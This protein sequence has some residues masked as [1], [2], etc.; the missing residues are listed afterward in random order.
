MSTST[1]RPA[2]TARWLAPELLIGSG[3]TSKASDVYAYACVC[4]EIF[5]GGCHPFPELPNE[6][7]VALSVTQGKR[8]VRPRNVPKLR[9]E[10]WAL[11]ELCWDGVPASRPTANQ[12]LAR[13]LTIDTGNP[14]FS[15]AL[16]WDESV[17]SQVWA[18]VEYRP[19]ATE[20]LP[21]TRRQVRGKRLVSSS[22]AP[23][24]GPSVT[25]NGKAQNLF[26]HSERTTSRNVS[27]VQKVSL[28]SYPSTS[29][30]CMETP[31]AD[32]A[33]SGFQPPASTS[34][35]RLNSG[36]NLQALGAA[37][38][39]TTNHRILRSRYAEFGS[40][41]PVPFIPS[42]PGDRPITTS[43]NA[44][45][46]RPRFDKHADRKREKLR[47]DRDRE[48]DR[49]PK[50]ER[51]NVTRDD[52]VPS[53]GFGSRYPVDSDDS[54]TDDSD[55]DESA[56]DYSA[57]YIPMPKP[58]PE[59][60]TREWEE[61]RRKQEQRWMAEHGRCSTMAEENRSVEDGQSGPGPS[62][63]QSDHP[64]P[65]PLPLPLPAHAGSTSTSILHSPQPLHSAVSSSP[66]RPDDTPYNVQEPS[67][68]RHRGLLN[69]PT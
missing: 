33:S 19:L 35:S 61:E 20:S 42:V 54:D 22:Y 45:K 28:D 8:P 9:N 53:I 13:I 68:L 24:G 31:P 44:T 67:Q 38:P 30:P 5:T 6:M 12:L 51:R 26:E 48:F 64:R 21:A 46:E 25:T 4:Y 41:A 52:P 59:V 17:F 16:D 39:D 1:S 32:S 63:L 62:R 27:R 60:Y 69:F 65:Y 23:P 43:R 36:W 37:L 11:M 7:A 49:R 10:M 57:E 40:S 3:G 29:W 50:W 58:P 14:A 47:R 56:S 34:T 15:P 66:L 2:G 55:A 18:N